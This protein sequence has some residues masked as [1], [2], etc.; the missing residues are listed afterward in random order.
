MQARDGW[1]CRGLLLFAWRE[2]SPCR[3]DGSAHVAA[4]AELDGHGL[5]GADGVGGGEIDHR[6][7]EAGKVEDT[8]GEA[9]EAGAGAGT[10]VGTRQREK[11]R[12]VSLTACVCAT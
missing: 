10:P 6:P 9:R 5:A 7:V 3:E 2:S 4:Q 1:D 8:A 11:R 12:A